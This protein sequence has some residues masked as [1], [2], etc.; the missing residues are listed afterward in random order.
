MDTSKGLSHFSVDKYHTLL[1]SG[2]I[3]LVSSGLFNTAREMC[4]TGSALT[5][6]AK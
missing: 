4:V 6:T 2:L 1:L 3:L 5:V